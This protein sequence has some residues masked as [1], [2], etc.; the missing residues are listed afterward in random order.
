MLQKLFWLILTFR[1]S[2]KLFYWSQKPSLDRT[3]KFL[4]V[5]Q[6]NFRNIICTIFH[7][8]V[9]LGNKERFDKEQIGVKEP[10]S[11]T[12]CQFTSNDKEQF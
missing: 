5:G 9:K 12:N 4:T 7:C 1:Y 11:M 8:T 6:K 3:K 2:N 10:F